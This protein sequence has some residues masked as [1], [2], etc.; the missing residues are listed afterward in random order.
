MR[1]FVT[2]ATGFI[3]TAL[4]RELLDHGHK[5]LGL[6]RSEEGAK[7]LAAAG[8]EVHRGNIDDLESIRTGAAGADAV[9]HLAFNHDF[10]DFAKVCDTDRRVIE[11]IGTALAGS[12][13][14]M[15]ITSGTAMAATVPGKLATEDGPTLSAKQFPRV[16]SEETA[17]S[18]KDR[19]VKVAIVRLPQVHDTRK[20]GLITYA[21][22]IARKTGAVAYVGEG[23]NRWA[24]G[25]LS[26]TARLYRLALEKKASGVYHAVGEEGVAAK[27][28]AEAVA[29]G[30]KLP[31]RSITPEEAQATMG[32]LAHFAAWDMPA[33]SAITQKALNW[34]PTGTDLL[35]DLN[36]MNYAQL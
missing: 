25:H 13:R 24:A 29:R 9:A 3:G 34:K 28:I 10:S 33:S 36:N 14:T 2:G 35:T 20:A 4:V 18:F 26:D 21:I 19:G 22:E 32:F 1:V 15:V 23:R 31:A 30:M 7:A 27:D 12:N 16:A 6:T 8:A 5:V 11:T 17:Q